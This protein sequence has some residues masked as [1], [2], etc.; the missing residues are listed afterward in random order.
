MAGISPLSL[1]R[2]P[3][4]DSM[5]PLLLNDF[6]Q[7]SNDPADSREQDR[8]QQSQTEPPLRLA[9]GHSAQGETRQSNSFPFDLLGVTSGRSDKIR[10]ES[11][12]SHVTSSD[13]N[14]ATGLFMWG[15]N[16]YVFYPAINFP[17]DFSLSSSFYSPL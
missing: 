14:R 10:N 6:T 3:V 5:Q 16:G 1:S 4:P 12:A 9:R 11:D 2:R 13:N 7:Q 8:D 15:W 17:K